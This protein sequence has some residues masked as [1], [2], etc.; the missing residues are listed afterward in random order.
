[1][2]PDGG[3]RHQGLDFS[4]G[5][6]KDATKQSR[7]RVTRQ[8]LILA[9]AQQQPVQVL[10][11]EKAGSSSQEQSFGI[12]RDRKNCLHKI[13]QQ[14]IPREKNL[15]AL[16]LPPVYDYLPTTDLVNLFLLL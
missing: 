1:M 7:F 10:R 3:R 14:M 15:F 16:K 8:V 5:E 6:C 13:C 11:L 4:K 9:N 12:F 2:E